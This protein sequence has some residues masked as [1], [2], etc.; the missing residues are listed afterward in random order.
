[1]PPKMER[2]DYSAA[3]H[4]YD[5]DRDDDGVP[6][7]T[8]QGRHDDKTS[9]VKFTG[10][11]A[12]KVDSRGEKNPEAGARG[13]KGSRGSDSETE[14]ATRRRINRALKA[15]KQPSRKDIAI[16]KAAGVKGKQKVGGTTLRNLGRR[17][18]LADSF[19]QKELLRQLT[20]LSR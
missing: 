7:A 2:P 19:S 1:M 16:L 5:Y 13:R 20:L 14:S 10:K 12:P 17:T 3:E 8:A 6:D 15:G 11:S 4:E 9:P 18:K